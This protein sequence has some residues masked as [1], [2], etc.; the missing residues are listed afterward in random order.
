MSELLTAFALVLVLEGIFPFALPQAWRRAMRQ[1]SALDDN[2][3]RIVGAVSMALGL[4]L[5]YFVR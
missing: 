1:A 4:I 2:S 5:L 3:L